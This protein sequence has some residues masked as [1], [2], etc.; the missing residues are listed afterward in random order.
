MFMPTH[1]RTQPISNFSFAALLTRIEMRAPLAA[2][3]EAKH[4]SEKMTES[5]YQTEFTNFVKKYNKKYTV[6]T[7][8]S[9]HARAYRMLAAA[10]HFDAVVASSPSLPT[11]VAD[12]CIADSLF[13][14][15]C[16]CMFCAFPAR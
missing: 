5:Q 16:V 12:A 13:S 15:L 14:F 10:G 7:A 9:R 8:Q 3:N 6:R 4:A 2:Y 11:A 1:C